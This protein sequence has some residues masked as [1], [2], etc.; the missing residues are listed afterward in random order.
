MQPIDERKR[1]I[2]GSIWQTKYVET[3][4]GNLCPANDLDHYILLIYLNLTRIIQQ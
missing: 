3:T 1:V 2:V 4:I